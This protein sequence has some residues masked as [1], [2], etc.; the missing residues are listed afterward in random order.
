MLDRVFAS[1]PEGEIKRTLFFMNP[2]LLCMP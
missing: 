1:S 2:A